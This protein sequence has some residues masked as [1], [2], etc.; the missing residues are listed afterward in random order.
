MSRLIKERIVRQY[1][2]RFGDVSDVAVVSTQ[3][4]DVLGLTAFRRALRAKGIRAMVIQNRLAKLA[5][6]ETGLAPLGTLLRGP[7]TLVWGGEGI[8]DI[9]KVLAAEVK[10]RTKIQICG[11]VT[12]GQVLSKE[13]IETLSKMPSR[14]ELIG[15]AVGRAMGAAARVAAQVRSAGGR[16]VAQVREVEKKALA[17]EVA[18]APEAAPALP[19]AAAPAEG[20]APATE[21]AA[22]PAAPA[23]EGGAAPA[24]EAP[25]AEQPPAA[26]QA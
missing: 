17:S 14:Q 23:A 9:A 2:S 24:A 12:A 1:Q 5:L 4:V 18:P 10:T 3:G 7:A 13:D 25:K 11:G 16:L 21:A 20:A 15:M 22:A 19:P 8:V 6:A 26:P